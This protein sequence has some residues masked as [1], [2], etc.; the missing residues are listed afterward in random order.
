[1][2]AV[3]DMTL[4][5]A[6]A[7]DAESIW[8]WRNDPASRA[9]SGDGAHIDLTTHRAWLART[10]ADPDRRLL[11]GEAGG[12]SVG[13]VR[14]DR[15]EGGWRVSLNLAPEARGQGLGRRLLAQGVEAMARQR[16]VADIRPENHASVRTFAAYGFVQIGEAGGFLQFVREPS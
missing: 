9:A 16:L 15:V 5:E 8:L 7:A 4:R 2:I 13:M 3:A 11:I 6:A 1:M 12:R 10:L 14:F